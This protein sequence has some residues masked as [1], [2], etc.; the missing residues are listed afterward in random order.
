MAKRIL[1]VG[2]GPVGAVL[3]LALYK[4]GVPVTLIE[5]EPAPVEDQ[6]A[7]SIQ[8]TSVVMLDDLGVASEVIE[9]G[10]KAP[11]F[12]YR[13]RTTGEI[14]GAFDHGLLKD[15]IRFPFVV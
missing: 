7:A 13:D 9:K 10:F 15:D 5:R 11:Y 14:V 6:R 1:V 4:S 12:H 8:P 2:A 3:T